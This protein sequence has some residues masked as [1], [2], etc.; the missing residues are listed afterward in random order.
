M[1]IINSFNLAKLVLPNLCKSAANSFLP[2]KGAF[3]IPSSN[4][5]LL[6][7]IC[8]ISPQLNF[9]DFIKSGAL[10]SIAKTLYLAGSTTKLLDS[11]PFF[12]IK[13]VSISTLFLSED[14]KDNQIPPSSASYQRSIAIL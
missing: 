4:N 14:A 5:L 9:V 2:T 10:L 13:K 7:L 1:S 3:S 12:K 8:L 11:T 6:F